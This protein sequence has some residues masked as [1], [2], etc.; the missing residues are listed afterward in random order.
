MV[1]VTDKPKSQA[2]ML[3]D[4]HVLP[5]LEVLYR[6]AWSLTRSDADAQDLV[7]DTLLRAYRSIERFDGRYP[8][9]W[10]LTIMRNANINRVRKKSPDLL[11]EP[12]LT[13]E[14]S[15]DFADH[16]D[17]ETLVIE[18]ELDGAIERAFADLSSD[19]RQIVEL[20]DL[21]GLS[22]QEAAETLDIPIGTVMSRL[23]RA[24]GRIRDY[25]HE[26][27]LDQEVGR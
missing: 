18:P 9:A 5:E 12:D 24:R 27:G 25:L 3:F 22:Y 4:R 7:Q 16:D 26:T 2:G 14:R 17:P 21:N 10:L 1:I 11:A 15:T 23:H 19:F 8:R 20:V 6:T 13:F